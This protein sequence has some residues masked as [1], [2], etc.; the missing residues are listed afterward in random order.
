MKKISEEIAF[1]KNGS[2]CEKFCVVIENGKEYLQITDDF[3]SSVLVKSDELGII[4]VIE[5]VY[6]SIKK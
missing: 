5:R 4:D 2:C 1:C 3:G 6:R